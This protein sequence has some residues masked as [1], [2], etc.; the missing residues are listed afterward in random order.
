MGIVISGAFDVSLERHLEG[1]KVA[2][3]VREEVRS[4]HE[5]LAAIEAPAS[6]APAE[7]DAVRQ[8]VRAAFVDGFRRVMG[9]CALLALLSAACAALCVPS[10]P[11]RRA[12]RSPAASG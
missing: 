10:A 12:R 7:R 11:T 2:P 5:K 8:S 6:A 4:Q 3:R 1:A 9:T